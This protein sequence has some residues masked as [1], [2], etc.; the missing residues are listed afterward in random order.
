[1]N[2]T[3]SVHTSLRVVAAVAVVVVLAGLLGI[4]LLALET[5]PTTGVAAPRPPAAVVPPPRVAA[6]ESLAVPCWGCPEAEGWPLRFRTD[7]D[8]LAPLGTGAGN[9][10]EFFKDFA[11]P[12][13]SRF[14]EAMA[15]VER[16]VD[17]PP[18][19]D[20][21]LPADDPLLLEAEP[22][23]DQAT[24]RFYPEYFKVDGW[25]TQ[26]PNLILP[27][28][29][30]RSWVARGMS[31]T[32]PARAMEDFRRAIRLGR[33]LRQEDV[34]VIA[35]LVGLACIRLGA[36]GIYDTAV[37]HGDSRL[38][39]VA[40]IVVGEHAPQR[41]M[42]SARLTR[43]DLTPYLRKGGD[44]KLTLALPDAR[45]EAI[46]AAAKG[47]PDRRFRGEAIIE[48]NVVRSLGTSSQRD[49]A[50]GLLAELAA[51]RDPIVAA[52]AAWSRDTQLSA[53]ALAGVFQ[54]EE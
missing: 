8:V 4:R 17:G 21:V 29:L 6:P 53:E 11:K 45:L 15:A 28:N 35:D 50:S 37:R 43:T 27:L 49:R 38:A 20:K 33:L 54:I 14:P 2:A 26:L 39:L 3:K 30:A 36:Q 44:A 34:T 31:A 52:T 5:P 41:L 25:S 19:L 47:D 23:C 32:D 13:G 40:A 16:R 42:T 9:A 18:G 51:E 24:M 1:M 48:L 22:W 12:N 10:A 7:L 46:L